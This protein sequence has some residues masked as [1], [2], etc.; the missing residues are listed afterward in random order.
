MDRKI[1]YSDI[2]QYSAKEMLGCSVMPAVKEFTKI[3]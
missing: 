2:M 3:E 1:A